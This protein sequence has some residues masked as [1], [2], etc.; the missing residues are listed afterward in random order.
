MV[1]LALSTGLISFC[2][3]GDDRWRRQLLAL[4]INVGSMARASNTIS[5]DKP[6]YRIV[7]CPVCTA[8][9][10]MLELATNF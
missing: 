9:P 5:G 4:K 6:S 8:P 3:S 7:L 10:A 1:Q 2:M